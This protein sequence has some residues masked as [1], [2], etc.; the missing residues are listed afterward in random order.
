MTVIMIMLA[1]AVIGMN[2]IWKIGKKQW[3]ALGGFSRS[4]LNTAKCINDWEEMF[5]V[6]T[7][8]KRSGIFFNI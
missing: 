7:R 1:A 3:I 6:R 5:S 8:K 2:Y 4:T